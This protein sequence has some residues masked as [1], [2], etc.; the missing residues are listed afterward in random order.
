[1]KVYLV[2]VDIGRVNNQYATE[3]EIRMITHS[4]EKAEQKRQ[5]MISEYVEES[6][7]KWNERLIEDSTFYG[8]RIGQTLEEFILELYNHG[9]SKYSS[10]EDIYKQWANEFEQETFIDEAELNTDINITMGCYYE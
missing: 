8:L 9:G 2:G 10:V 1:M 3:V 4:K 5:S 7:N 6:K